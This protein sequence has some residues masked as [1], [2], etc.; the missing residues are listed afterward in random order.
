M[1]LFSDASGYVTEPTSVMDG[2]SGSIASISATSASRA[3]SLVFVY[4]P[5][6]GV[7]L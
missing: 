1:V 2:A 4:S 3:P 6:S 5:V 7:P